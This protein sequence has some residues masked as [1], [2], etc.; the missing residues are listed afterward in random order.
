[1][2][3][4]NVAGL[5]LILLIAWWFWFYQ[6]KKTRLND[7]DL[8]IILENGIYQPAR[9]TLPSDKGFSVN[10][11]RKDP[12]PCAETLLI[13]DLQISE[14]LPL[15]KT[16]NIVLPPIPKG[17]YSFHCQMQMYRGQLIIE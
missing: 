17:E 16:K 14:T 15:N 1:M 2:F 9:I 11:L 8:L 5:L 13:P 6:P 10:F 3:F 4:V 7:S 12:S